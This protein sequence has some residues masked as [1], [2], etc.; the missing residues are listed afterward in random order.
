MPRLLDEIVEQAEAE[1]LRKGTQ[2]YE[3]RLV[4]LKVEKCQEMRGVTCSVCPLQNSCELVTKFHKLNLQRKHEREQDR[5]KRR[6]E[7]AAERNRPLGPQR[8]PPGGG[9]GTGGQP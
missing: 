7:S 1:G 2:Q 4:G 8:P 5:V 9:H 3:D 6:I